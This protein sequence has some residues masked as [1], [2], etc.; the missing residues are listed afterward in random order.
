MRGVLRLIRL[1]LGFWIPDVKDTLAGSLLA[2]L[3]NLLSLSGCL[4][5]RILPFT[6]SSQSDEFS[7]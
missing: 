3:G 6:A 1:S 4:N 5:C 2:A 7:H